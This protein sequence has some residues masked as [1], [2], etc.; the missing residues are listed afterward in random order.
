MNKIQKIL[1]SV[2]MNLW[3]KKSNIKNISFLQ[4]NCVYLKASWYYT[5]QTYISTMKH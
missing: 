2:S 4:F 3:F 5:Y 1:I